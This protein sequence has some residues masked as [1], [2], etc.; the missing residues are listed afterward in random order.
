MWLLAALVGAASGALAALAFPPADWGPLAFIAL[1]PLA[2]LFR[3]ARTSQVAA[4]AAAFGV[5]FFSLLL[6]WIH[7]FGLVAY[8]LLVAVETLFVVAA[9]ALGAVARRHL[10][11][12]LGVLAFPT[13]YLAA[14][15]A[16]SHL[17]VGG[18]PWGGL[19]YSQH[20]NPLVL[21][22]AAYTGVWGVTFLVATV[23]ALVAEAGAGT[24][25]ALRDRSP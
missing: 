6:P 5:A 21:H 22:L 17:P 16:R 4:A 15:Y 24:W 12:R 2:A 9:M 25:A 8:L 20:N 18:F 23:N 10:P 1:V 19:G 3:R 11:G 13:A 7:L 14:E